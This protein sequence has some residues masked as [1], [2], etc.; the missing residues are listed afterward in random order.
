MMGSISRMY[1]NVPLDAAFERFEKE[2]PR[3]E[4]SWVAYTHEEV[5]FDDELIFNP[6][7]GKLIRPN[8]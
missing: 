5:E 8:S 6:T 3:S 1:F 2:H 7:M 4:G